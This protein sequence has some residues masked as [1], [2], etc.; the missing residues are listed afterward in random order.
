MSLKAFCHAVQTQWR[1]LVQ[2]VWPERPA[3]LCRNE[4]ERLDQIIHRRWLRLVVIRQRIDRLLTSL[5]RQQGRLRELSARLLTAPTDAAATA[6]AT[7][8]QAVEQKRAKV[9]RLERHY[10]RA[11]DALELLRQARRALGRGEVVV[12]A[13]WVEEPAD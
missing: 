9:E 10:E 2:T 7:L 11:C 4:Q 1:T 12:N 13:R 6:W 5:G 3:D 8:Q